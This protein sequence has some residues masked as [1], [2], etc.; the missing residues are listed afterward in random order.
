MLV[1]CCSLLVNETL[2]VIGLHRPAQTKRTPIRGPLEFFTVTLPITLSPDRWSNWPFQIDGHIMASI[3]S[4]R[5]LFH[6]RY[7]CYFFH[8]RERDGLPYC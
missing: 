6:V 2:F 5:L 1:F 7:P 8:M 4:A 3:L